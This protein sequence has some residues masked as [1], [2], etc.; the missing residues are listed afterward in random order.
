MAGWGVRYRRGSFARDAANVSAMAK[1]GAE[2]IINEELTKVGVAGERE[3]KKFVNRAG[4]GTTWENGPFPD[5]KQGGGLR[6]APS[7][8][9]VNTGE[10]RDALTYKLK[11]GGNVLVQV[12]VGWPT[13]F[14][15]YFGYQDQGFSA[16]GY[17]ERVQS[18]VRAVEGMG[19]MAYMRFFMRDQMQ[20]AS[21]RIIKRLSDDAF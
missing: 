2:K 11:K 21:D 8:G 1:S 9:R 5:L 20:A 10:M 17:R 16:G 19:L 3:A 6:D 15:D 12:E 14:K 4:T 18:P 13:R 7:R